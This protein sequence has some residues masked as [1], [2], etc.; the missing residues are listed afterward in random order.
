MESHTCIHTYVGIYPH[1]HKYSLLHFHASTPSLWKLVCASQYI[2][3]SLY[4]RLHCK[5]SLLMLKQ[6]LAYI[7][8]S[9]PPSQAPLPSSWFLFVFILSKWTEL[10]LLPRSEKQFGVSSNWVLGVL[11]NVSFI[12][13]IAAPWGLNRD[14]QTQKFE[15]HIISE[16]LTS[17]DELGESSKLLKMRDN[18]H[19]H[20]RG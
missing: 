19:K 14:H 9:R 5:T 16:L 18:K 15:P 17:Q 13:S 7:C 10:C 2:L 4:E 11:W 8:H 12:V 20:L 3:I 6:R 1:T